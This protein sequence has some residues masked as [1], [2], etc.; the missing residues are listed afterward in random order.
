MKRIHSHTPSSFFYSIT[1]Q[2]QLVAIV[3]VL[4]LFLFLFLTSTPLHAD[5]DGS[6][7]K[8]S[9]AFNS[10][11]SSD[12]SSKE[13]I[14][15]AMVGPMTGSG[16]QSGISIQRGI[17]MYL[18]K[19]NK[20]GGVN[21]RLVRLVVYD[22]QNDKVEAKKRAQEIAEKDQAIAVI[23][24]VY[25][26]CSMA[27]GEV[28][29][30]KGIPAISPSSTHVDVTAE[31]PYFFRTIFSDNLQGR[32]LANYAQRVFRNNRVFIIH[33]ERPY[34][35]YLADIFEETSLGLQVEISGREQLNSKGEDVAGQISQ[36]I[37]VLKDAENPG[38][39]FLATHATEGA[40]LVKAIRQAG[41]KN[42][43]ITPDAFNSGTFRDKIA[44]YEKEMGG[45]GYYS[46]GILV[47]S[48]IVYDIANDGIQQFRQDYKIAFPEEGDPDW[49][50]VTAYDAAVAIVE[51]IRET[52]STC[53]AA[54][55]QQDRKKVRDF[56]AKTTAIKD[57]IHGLSG[58]IYFDKVGNGI[59]PLA[60]AEYQTHQLISSLIQFQPVA[61]VNHIKNL[62]D[63]M[64]S[65]RVMKVDGNY[66]YKT[67]VAYTGIELLSISDLDFRQASCTLEFNIWF[68]FQGEADACKIEFL[69][70]LEPIQLGE[71]ISKVDE[72]L[73]SYRQFH[74]K[75]KFKTDFL[76]SRVGF[77]EHVVGISLRHRDLS[78]DNLVFVVDVMGMGL[79]GKNSM[80]RD[81][82]EAHILAGSGGWDIKRADFFQNTFQKISMGNPESLSTVEGKVHYSRFNLKLLLQQEQINLRKKIPVALAPSL[83]SAAVVL[84]FLISLVG[85]RHKRWW[86]WVLKVIFSIL[87]LFSLEVLLVDGIQELDSI[88][89]KLHLI[90]QG[91]SVLWWII[92]AFLL[93]QAIEMFIWHPLEEKTGNQVPSIARSFVKLFIF[94]A[95][96]LFIIAFVF[97]LKITSMLATSGVIAM[98]I[99]LALQVNLSN[100]MS[101]LAISL[102]QPFKIGDWI[103]IDGMEAARVIEMNWRTVR[104]MTVTD[105]IYCVPNSLAAESRVLNY[106]LPDDFYW[107]YF[108]VY[109]S[110]RFSPERVMKVI[111]DAL[112][113]T[114]VV[115]RHMGPNVR[116]NYT[117]KGI[118]YY[119]IFVLKGYGS[120]SGD[121]N[122]VSKNIWKHLNR[123]GMTPAVPRQEIH[124]TRGTV[125]HIEEAKTQFSIIEDAEIFQDLSEEIKTNL[126]AHTVQ[127]YTPMGEVIFRQGDEA[128]SMFIIAQGTVGIR[129]LSEEGEEHISTASLAPGGGVNWVEVVHED[130]RKTRE[131]IR[132]GAGGC[133]GEMGLL[134]GEPRSTD[135][136]AVSDCYLLEISTEVLAPLVKDNPD[137]LKCFDTGK[138]P[139]EL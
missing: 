124:L 130:D 36:I 41:I 16:K 34:G 35:L 12:T 76:P 33:E 63:A 119:P 20:A 109:V 91:F 78:R 79:T 117:D 94:T 93:T 68:R 128:S 127:R 72:T 138:N 84:F 118:A 42:I 31:N 60:I 75:G 13:E 27:A 83:L 133:I 90:E 74:V 87:I 4:F 101:G 95:A 2:K 139:M 89:Y 97:D 129:E 82:K 114:S 132:L 21:G 57:A 46:N 1:C 6:F 59:K 137:S 51:A 115:Q 29:Q 104:L 111:M 70:A 113:E 126:A 81:L 107:L 7:K 61:N 131:V 53:S 103:S 102:E 22:D 92:P 120:R 25:S 9:N 50:A 48:P 23:G 24:H 54:T 100:V 86:V 45:M 58:P 135:A 85:R 96:I 116:M 98:I 26:S 112:L 71:P 18:D 73:I 19:I 69:N 66:M 123:A 28:Y 47:A 43:I 10:L 52:K 105:T 121:K 39:I 67:N 14:F 32:F 3:I 15:I 30:E 17:E 108:P 99:G 5:S 8:I 88:A 65:E 49:R 106:H 110:S 40:M 80:T 55:I 64:Q 136:V 38:T 37:H 62:E 44:E 77:G 11:I 125:D 122:A 56:L 134:Q